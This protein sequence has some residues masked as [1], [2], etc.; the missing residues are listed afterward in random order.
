[1]F[2]FFAFGKVQKYSTTL[3]RHR[4]KIKNPCFQNSFTVNSR[5]CLKYGSLGRIKGKRT[6]FCQAHKH[7][8]CRDNMYKMSTND[9][10]ESKLLQVIRKEK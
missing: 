1:M 4:M 8:L 5:Q 6:S 9:F 10:Y 3:K 2:L 7:A